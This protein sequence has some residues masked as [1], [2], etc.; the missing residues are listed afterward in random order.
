MTSRVCPIGVG[1][2]V[3]AVASCL[4][5]AHAASAKPRLGVVIVFDQVR[6]LEIDRYA[7]FFGKGGFGG[8][9]GVGVDGARFDAYYAYSDTETG[10]GHATIATC[11]NPNVHGIGANVWF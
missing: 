3:V 9:E 1:V 8:L 6:A 7:P 2:G 5:G 4:L 11:A 10:P